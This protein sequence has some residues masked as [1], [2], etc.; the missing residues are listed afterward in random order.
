MFW[1]ALP[2]NKLVYL[3][4]ACGKCLVLKTPKADV[5]L[6]HSQLTFTCSKS[7]IKILENTLRY[8]Q[9]FTPF[10]VFIVGF[11]QVNVSWKDFADLIDV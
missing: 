6:K 9:N 8:V 10:S 7:A 3:H 1:A 5:S 11:E 4:E 2:V